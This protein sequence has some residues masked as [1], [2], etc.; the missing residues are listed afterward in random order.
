MKYYN[1]FHFYILA[2]LV[3]LFI[4]ASYYRFVVK[5]DYVVGYE[6]ACDPIVESCFIGCEDDDCTEEYYYSKMQKYAPDLYA[7]CGESIIECELAS[8]CLPEDRNCSIIY[9]DAETD[10]SCETL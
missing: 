5:Q 6:G 9:C 7:E 4:V 2:F 10:D 1:N 3:T 8:I